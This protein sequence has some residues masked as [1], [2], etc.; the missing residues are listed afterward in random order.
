MTGLAEHTDDPLA[1]IWALDRTV[2]AAAESGRLGTGGG[3]LRS[4]ARAHRR[5][6]EP[7]LRWHATY[8]AAGLAQLRGDLEEAEHLAGAAR[9][10]GRG[11]RA[12]PTRS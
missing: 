1:R 11:R 9:R 10:L 12:S 5:A 8:Y 6:R 3:R 2:H 4:A 7:R